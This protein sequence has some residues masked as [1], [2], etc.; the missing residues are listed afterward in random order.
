VCMHKN[1]LF[2]FY[3]QLPPHERRLVTL[4][5]S[6]SPLP[7]TGSKGCIYTTIDAFMPPHKSYVEACM[8]SAEVFLR[9]RPSEREII[10][11]YN[12]D[13]VKFFRVLQR[14]EKLAYLIGR[15]YLSFNSEQLF[16]ANKAMLADVPNILD[17]LTETSV[18]IENADWSDIEK[19]VAFFEN[20]IFSFSSTGKT[21]AIAK[22]DMTKRFGR[23]VAAC[24]RLRN[25]VIMHRDYKD[26]IAYAAGKDT[27]ILLDPPYKGTENYY[28]KASFGSDEH[29]M[30]FE[31]MNG[32]HEKYKGECKFIIT[33]NNDPYIVDLANKYGF[34]I[35]YD[36][37][38]LTDPKISAKY[39]GEV[40]TDHYGRKVPKHAHGT[41]N[42]KRKTSSSHIITDATMK[43]YDRIVDKNL[44]VRRITIAA[45]KLVRE[46][47][48][49][50]EREAEQLTLFDDPEE[51]LRKAQEE[52]DALAQEKKM[53][54][55]I[56]EIKKRF[57]KNAILKG[58]NLQEGATAKD[59]NSQVGG[60]KA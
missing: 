50:Q 48:I 40:T 45:C 21:F 55:A 56:L 1:G 18:I 52:E 41:T 37:E 10:N 53:Q 20:Q 38:N 43:L 30:L 11:D 16:K 17:D 13:L 19:A 51:L 35:G 7:W 60:H 24:S 44:L 5:G 26:C 59:R 33:Y 36:I 47:E 22:K 23:L 58:M 49:P 27:F 2:L 25:A 46:S 9:K 4:S 29:A 6:V 3:T 31:F 8:G 32:V 39:H 12:G 14:S 15:L 28:Q 54:K 34:D 57:G 42:L